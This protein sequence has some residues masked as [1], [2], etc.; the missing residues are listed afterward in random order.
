MHTA[1][2]SRREKALQSLGGLKNGA[3]RA[4][5]GFRV[6]WFEVLG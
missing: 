1:R 5:L 4:L 6:E 3:R 2:R